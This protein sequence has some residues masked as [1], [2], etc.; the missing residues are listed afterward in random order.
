MTLNQCV[1]CTSG[2]SQANT[3]THTKLVEVKMSMEN[4]SPEDASA[5]YR[6]AQQQL[7]KLQKAMEAIEKQLVDHATS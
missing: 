5:A 4:G 3:H 7:E 2:P 1:E 6:Q